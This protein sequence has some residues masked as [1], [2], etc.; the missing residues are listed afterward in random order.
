M[1]KFE[2]GE[3]GKKIL[4][5]LAAAGFIATVCVFPGVAQIYRLFDPKC[6]K[7]EYKIRRSFESLKKQKLV[8]IIQKSEK[9]YLEITEKGK[10]KILQFKVDAIEIKKQNR[11]DKKWRIVIFDIPEKKKLARD[12]LNYKLKELGFYPIQKST[13]IYPY[14]CRDEIDFIS[15]FYFVQKYVLYIEAETISNETK[16]KYHFNL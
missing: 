3:L 10:R 7:D 12:T 1:D 13:F 14:P 5:G 2:R 9:E 6:K 11:W 8:R 4:I 16:I 15:N